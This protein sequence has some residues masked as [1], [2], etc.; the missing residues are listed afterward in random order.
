VRAALRPDRDKET[1]RPCERLKKSAEFERALHKGKRYV[2]PWF[3]AFVL[4]TE[5]PASPDACVG[6]GRLGL[7]VS[8]RVGQA[9]HRNRIKRLFREAYRREKHLLTRSFDIVLR[10]RSGINVPSLRY[11]QVAQALRK[12]MK[13]LTA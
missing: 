11:E 2:T 9:V 5:Q 10:A 4:R 6:T 8:R 1:F 13:E 3:V 12:L 7:I